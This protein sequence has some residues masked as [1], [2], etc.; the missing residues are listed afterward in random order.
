M[1]K[2][3]QANN[4]KPTEP[5]SGS[6]PAQTPP[7][8]RPDAAPRTP[9]M[10]RA[11]DWFVFLAVTA[12]VFLGYYLT[13]A[14]E[15]T[16]EDSGELATAS[17][18]AGIP[19]PPGYPVW[20][21]YT[22]VW[23]LLPFG[24]IAWRV[25][26]GEA[27]AGAVASG[28][29]AMLVSRGSS[30]MIEGIAELKNFDRRWENVI[31]VVSGFVAGMLMGFN[32]FMWSQSVIVEVY[33]FSLVS[34]MGVML[35]LMRWVYAPNQFRYLFLAFFLHGICFNN[36]QSL[37]VAVLSMEAIVF[38]VQ[39]RLAREL[40]FWNVTLYLLGLIINPTTLTSNVPVQVIFH[41]V[42]IVSLG[43]W[44][45][46]QFTLKRPTNAAIGLA[47]V[48]IGVLHRLSFEAAS[49]VPST[50]G[51]KGALLGM[52]ALRLYDIY[53]AVLVVKKR[54]REWWAAL[55]CGISWLLGAAFYF[56]MPLSGA[57]VPPMQ[58]G[59][60]R[61]VEGF[62]HAFTRGQYDKIRPTSGSGNGIFEVANNFIGTYAQQMWM[63]L[64]GMCDEFSLVY[65]LLAVL[66]FVF[67]RRM[68][69]RERDW[70]I[71]LLAMF[72]IL[73]PGLVLLLNPGLDRQA[74]ELNRVF[75]TASHAFVAMSI[76]YGLTLVA[77]FL[78]TEY[79]R[80]R[81]YCLIGGGVAA[82]VAFLALAYNAQSFFYD[83]PDSN[84]IVVMFSAIGS[85]PRHLGTAFAPNHFGLPVL[86]DVIVLLAVLLFLA[87]LAIWRARAPLALTLALFATMP[88]YSVLSHW[89][90]NEQ[91]N[92]WF[93]YWFG[94]DMF[95]PPFEG[96]D[97]QF[98]YDAKLR[99]QMMKD[100][101]KGKY[102]Y[103]EM[104]RNAVLYGG[105]DPGRF[106]PTYMIFCDSFIPA[107]CK[108]AADPGFD[109]R[110]VYIITQNAL[111]DGT[112]LDYVRS[113]YNRSAQHDR[114]F[115]QELLR[116]PR[117]RF[118][119][120]D[121][122]VLAR[123]AYNLLDKP[124]I[125]FG[126]KV[127][128]RRREEGVY[129]P[130]EIYIASADDSSRCFN[131]YM[132][133]A[134][135]RYQEGQLKPGEDFKT[136]KGR[137]QVSGQVAVMTINGLISKV[138]FDRNPDN[139]FY[140]EESFPLDWMYPHLTPF[141][142]I[143]KVNRQPLPA[144]TEDIM[145]RDHRFWS[146]FSER[147][148]GDWITYDTPVKEI[149]DFVK[150]THM[151]RDYTGFKGDLK[152][153]RDDS[154]QKA[155]SKLR[156]SIAGIYTW[157]LSA[158]CPPEY[159]PRTAHEFQQV[160]R[161]ADFALKQSFAFCPYSPEAVFRYVSL[162]LQLARLDDALLVAETCQKIDPNNLQIVELAKRLR[163]MKK[164]G[165]AMESATD[166]LKEMEESVRKQPTN[167][168]QALN[169]AATYLQ[170][171][172]VDKANEI[173]EGI[174][175]SPKVPAAALLAVAQGFAQMN[176][177]QGLE[178]TLQRLVQV[179]P[180]QPE[181]WLDLAAIKATLGKP[182]YESALARALELNAARLAKNPSAPDLRAQARRDSR[183]NSVRS[184]PEFQKLVGP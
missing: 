151:Q 163:D 95:T 173:L 85:L 29:L 168:Q 68:Q 8:S 171:Q 140:V 69:K 27:M 154:G 26:L 30:M 119:D 118:E 7:P 146:K 143:M 109:R 178:K 33:S 121:T 128:A 65:L 19:H 78:G 39:P 172:Q 183:F 169:L 74:I 86:A 41:I 55:V 71:G 72:V 179:T 105:T 110:D 6:T 24:N 181:A 132:I 153:V 1:D 16:L 5:G 60:P 102:V 159:R 84:F 87:G 175:D 61:T 126:A 76:G 35:G 134:Q 28:L 3:N 147:L 148:I 98:S 106:C 136:H 62:I 157:R 49:G 88:I 45:W 156:S 176:N 13:I 73:G 122:N 77:A 20:T 15:L 141:G 47:V 142:I 70:T 43:C 57:T 149:V 51:V 114:P 18:Y 14:P 96:P 31:C 170:L 180:D 120:Y 63:Y 137:V 130:K 21:L 56:Y 52:V 25:A 40:L 11:I 34:L 108:P 94:H 82:I 139:E 97:G 158:Q 83:A 66:M 91:R 164:T 152:F 117:E 184:R 38:V 131:E 101:E 155:F 174:I 42:G 12:M 37:L 4:K 58:W 67:F 22:W 124:L 75:F 9:P 17:F 107:R 32:G 104:A 150:K 161:E 127:E 103:P 125:E 100:P 111:A 54:T 81:P 44:A 162:L 80:F 123:L 92:H 112:Y 48:L 2:V 90:D 177:Y 64:Q 53:D 166:N 145:E 79:Q 99:E 115:F 138:M 133:D 23:T 182:D 167:Y 165:A 129:P 135:R 59:Y 160:A 36:H 116:G 50:L 144:I 93:G 113:Q 89:A 46:L 10:F